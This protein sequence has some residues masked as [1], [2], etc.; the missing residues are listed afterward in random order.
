MLAAH[1][2][3]GRMGAHGDQAEA[4]VEVEAAQGA[5]MAADAEVPLRAEGL[6]QQRQAERERRASRERRAL[7]GSSQ[8]IAAVVRT[9]SKVE[10]RSCPPRSGRSRS[11]DGRWLRS[12]MSEVSR[13]WK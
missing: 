3:L 4:G 9:S 13:L 12:A 10:R 8:A 5:G 11:V 6:G 2:A 1:G 7:R